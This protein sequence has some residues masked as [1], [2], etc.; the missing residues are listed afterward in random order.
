MRRWF[1]SAIVI[2]LPM[3][4]L[5]Q[6]A[7]QDSLAYIKGTVYTE[8]TRINQH[9]SE[10]K[11]TEDPV[12]Y[13]FVQMVSDGDTLRLAADGTGRFSFPPVPPGRK[14]IKAWFQSY[15]P[16]EGIL[17]AEAGAN[18][19]FLKI[20]IDRNYLAEAKVIADVPLV[21][22]RGDT[23]IFNAAAV[24]RMDGENAMEILRQMPGVSIE[25]GK[26]FVF[27]EEVKRTYTNGKLIYG[28]S[29]G[30]ALA[31][32]LADDVLQIAT[33]NEA[34]PQQLK[35]GDCHG[36]KDRVLDIRTRNP[37]VS[38]F[39]G[40][41]V[42]SAGAD[43]ARNEEEKV[44]ARYEAGAVGNFYSEKFL[45]YGR[46]H[47]N[48][49]DR[50]SLQ[51]NS[52]SFPVKTLTR[53][54]SIFQVGAGMEKHWGDRLTGNLFS[55]DYQ[56]KKQR[57]S[58]NTRTTTDY[59]PTLENP[60]ARTYRDTARTL[61]NN[62]EHLIKAA[63]EI[64]DAK[65]KNWICNLSLSLAT[66]NNLQYH[67]SCGETDDS[68]S[69]RQQVENNH[70]LQSL[71]GGIHVHWSDLSA[72]WG[73]VP[74]V[75]TDL[76]AGHHNAMRQQLDTLSTSFSQRYLSSDGKTRHLSA[77]GILGADFRLSNSEQNT[78]N[79]EVS[80]AC[81]QET[82]WK[83]NWCISLLNPNFP[84][85]YAPDSY[86][87]IWSHLGLQPIISYRFHAHRF[88]IYFTIS[89]LWS[90]LEDIEYMPASPPLTKW[91]FSPDVSMHLSWRGFQL[92]HELSGSLP[93]TAQ[94]RKRVDE[95]NPLFLQVG[96]PDLVQSQNHW[97]KI[98][99]T[100]SLKQNHTLHIRGDFRLQNRAIVSDISYYDSPATLA[101]GVAYAVPAGTTVSTFQNA[102]SPSWQGEGNIAFAGR[103]QALKLNYNLGLNLNA[104]SFS[105]FI[106]K[107]EITPVERAVSAIMSLMARPSGKI[108]VDLLEIPSYRITILD[109]Q[110]VSNRFE[111]ILSIFGQF[112][113]L[114]VG[115]IQCKY[116]WQVYRFFDRT[117]HDFDQHNMTLAIGCRLLKGRLGISLSA[118]DLLNRGT[119]MTVT[120]DAG[121]RS[122]IWDPSYGRY[123]LLSLS[124]R[125]NKTKSNVQT[126]T[127]LRNGASLK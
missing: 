58:K 85:N 22:H 44:Q 9:S 8:N 10:T 79:L 126:E 19:I 57:E 54:V 65:W 69:F 81:R 122:Q 3:A 115:F 93:N 111:N 78:S 35:R 46:I 27:G 95:S 61:S 51:R 103:I 89:P 110:T 105:N 106:N 39:D 70:N 13:A 29:P 28:D 100:H 119:S 37:I 43:A 26:I 60:F 11:K 24:K 7:Q 107:K 82:E 49:L 75:S 92:H 68:H 88:G 18:V 120:S 55:I 21:S 98:E 50:E 17:E 59:Y 101:M 86:D 117:G 94:F 20:E 96:N 116:A 41:A 23:I 73:F 2:L 118:N 90:R 16:Y 97:W 77:K 62:V 123:Y 112:S 66:G 80:I 53:D 30:S 45:A 125:L 42:L 127:F 33:Y 38:A 84:E 52:Y 114:K 109:G 74:F 87:F 71:Q 31:A 14:H 34:S 124:F 6:P 113:F 12:P 64:N 48:N 121:F 36:K 67:G 102:L 5:A 15:L 99:W 4:V 108:R 1:L 104:K 63:L 32:I 25:Q 91:F 76:S 47:T 40:Y 83:K 72:A 56:F